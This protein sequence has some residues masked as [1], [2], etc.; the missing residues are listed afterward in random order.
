M[1]VQDHPIAVSLLTQAGCHFCEQAKELLSRLAV[2]YPI[3]V[4]T[5]DLSSTEGQRPAEGGGFLFPP[6]I[7]IDGALFSYGRPPEK[8]LRR[9]L[10][11]RV[12]ARGHD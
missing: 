8:K 12:R 1:D 10:E 4:S 9:E 2:E 3:A 6:G 7:F 11:R 5:I